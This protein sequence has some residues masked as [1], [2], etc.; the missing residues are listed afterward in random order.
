MSVHEFARRVRDG[1]SRDGGRRRVDRLMWDVVRYLRDCDE[2]EMGYRE[3]GGEAGG[4]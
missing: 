3:Y 1:R 4:A 2:L